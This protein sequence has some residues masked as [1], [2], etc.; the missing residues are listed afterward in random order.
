MLVY[1]GLLIAISVLSFMVILQRF[2]RNLLSDDGYLMF[3]LPVK[4]GA[5]IISK[6]L[7][8][9]LWIVLSALIS[10][11]TIAIMTLNGRIIAFIMENLDN[12]LR[13]IHL[14]LGLNSVSYLFEAFLAGFTGIM[15][16]ILMIY[17][18]IS[19][20]HLLNRHKNLGAFGA[21]I[22]L[23][24]VSQIVM[25]LLGQIAELTR[26]SG[27]FDALP[28]TA[29]AH[30]AMLLLSALNIL[31]AAAYFLITNHILSRRLNLE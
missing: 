29:A 20:G 6:L 8:S 18:A 26:F 16:G 19:L 2:Q 14:Y 28:A 4:P 13:Q 27:W 30:V 7:V 5:L 17:A 9:I 10:L 1:I 11:A 12:W 25:T 24:I 21:F 22:G 15:N 23:S 31:F 3:T